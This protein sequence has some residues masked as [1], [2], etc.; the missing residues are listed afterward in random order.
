MA[1]LD[2]ATRCRRR[3]LGKRQSLQFTILYF[4]LPH[5]ST[6]GTGKAEA[7]ESWD[8][9]QSRILKD[10]DIILKY[11]DKMGKRK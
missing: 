11:W 2:F 8:Q 7:K 6:K 9:K 10:G 4:G 1:I 3:R 5:T